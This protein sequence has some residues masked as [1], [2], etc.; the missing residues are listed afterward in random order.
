[1][2][3]GCNSTVAAGPAQAGGLVLAI[4]SQPRRAFETAGFER[5]PG[6]GHPFP[7]FSRTQLPIAIR[8]VNLSQ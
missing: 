2:V 7:G 3:A 4:W 5:D 1:M 8:T 6:Y